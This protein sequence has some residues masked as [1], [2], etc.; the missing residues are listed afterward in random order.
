[1]DRSIIL[2]LIQ[3]T[4]ILLTFSLIY[5]YSNVKDEEYSKTGNKLLA[6]II[7]GVFG[8]I[9]MM[10]PWT[11]V[12]GIVFDTR[13]I[14]LSVAG[15]FFGT[16]PTLVAMI[17]TGLYRFMVGGGGV[18]MGIAVILTSG[19]I[20]IFWNKY[21]PNWKQKNC[22]LELLVMGV[23]VHLAMLGCA[24]LLPRGAVFPTIKKISFPLITIYSPGTMLL[25]LLMVRQFRNWQNRKAKDRLL[26]SERRFTEMLKNVNLISIILDF[27]GTITFC[28]QY[29]IDISGYSGDEIIGQNWF[30]KFVPEE[31]RSERKEDFKKVVEGDA[32]YPHTEDE[33]LIKSGGKILISWNNTM[34][35]DAD[36]Q[37]S[38][39]A[40]IGENITARRATEEQKMQLGNILEASL[41]EIF[42]FNAESLYF[43][44]VNFGAL[45]NLGYSP[46]NI[47]TLTPPDIQPDYRVASFRKLLAPLASHEKTVIQYETRNRRMNGTFYPVQ[48]HLQFFEYSN[49]RIFLAIMQDIT[50]R[51]LWEN[52]LI[53]ARK[54]AEEND[55]LKSIFLANMSHEIRT[56]MNAI[57]G[58][59][60]LLHSRTPDEAKRELF[61]DIIRSSSNRL[62]GII[63]DILDISKIEAKQLSLSNSECSIA[64]IFIKSTEAFRKSDLLIEKPDVS[65]HLNLPLKYSKFKM[66]TDRNRFQQVLDNLL[67]N[68][69]KYTETGKVE[70]GFKVKTQSEKKYLEV[71][72]RDTG[73]GIPSDMKDLVFER[74]RQVEEKVYHAGAGLGLSISKGIVDLWGG[75][76]WFT[77]RLNKGT[78]F[79]F[80]VPVIETKEVK[81]QTQDMWGDGLMIA[82]KTILIAEDDYSSYMYLKEL[83]S[84]ENLEILYA[85]NG[86]ILMDMLEK[87]HPD[88]II[89]D[90]NM[91]LKSGFTCLREMQKKGIKSGIIVQTAYAMAEERERCFSLGCQGYIAKPVDKGELYKV[92]NQVMNRG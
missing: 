36:G 16:I 13:S 45:K 68:A 28:N 38:G 18:W 79:Y 66:V 84:G 4:A 20:G 69:I 29:F 25:G 72:V 37:I 62:L 19:T 64:E 23:L 11:L 12:P 90:M 58:F 33:I 51:K 43:K 88:L 14:L 46:E 87:S 6:G 74:F 35:C 60:D 52:Q 39:T 24:F 56:P 78:T 2:G 91:P 65:L 47:K 31:E 48:V 80:T 81:D 44:Y 67:T 70:T 40:S 59:S 54:K 71:Y 5:D 73:I 86:Q 30:D 76:I 50:E 89:L 83:I 61:I 85:E 26:E 32:I 22:A 7:I 77:S 9:L 49:E 57:I 92:I 15:L 10:T 53:E 75:Q 82:N 34:L 1:M 3:N 17:I 21:R 42:V 55:R 41:N 27:K 8:I 63:N